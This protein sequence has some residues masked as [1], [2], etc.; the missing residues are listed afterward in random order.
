VISREL[1]KFESVVIR[2]LREADATVSLESIGFDKYSLKWFRKQLRSP[3][4]W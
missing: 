4:G 2:I 1:G 3:L